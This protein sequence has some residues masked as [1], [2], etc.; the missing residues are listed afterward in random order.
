MSERASIDEVKQ[1]LSSPSAEARAAALAHATAHGL[2]AGS[3]AS[4]VAA[5][6]EDS[7]EAVRYAAMSAFR[8]VGRGASDAVPELLRM[9][10]RAD[11]DLHLRARAMHALGVVGPAAQ[12]AVSPLLVRSVGEDRRAALEALAQIVDERTPAAVDAVVG[13]LFDED[14]GVRT[15]VTRALSE[16]GDHLA[17]RALSRAEAELGGEV[18]GHAAVSVLEALRPRFGP[19]TRALAHRVLLERLTGVAGAALFVERDDAA[20]PPNV[21]LALFELGIEGEW[22]LFRCLAR[23]GSRLPRA[24]LADAPP[25]LAARITVEAELRPLSALAALLA[26][27]APRSG[28]GVEVL[29][30]RAERELRDKA[31]AF[32]PLGDVIVSI[33]RLATPL[34]RARATA[35][36]GSAI[37]RSKRLLRRAE[38]AALDLQRRAAEALALLAPG[39]Q[40]PEL[41]VT[42]IDEAHAERDAA[43]TRL[44]PIRA[45]LGGKEPR[46]QVRVAK[47]KELLEL[48]RA[49]AAGA[50]LLRSEKIRKGAKPEAVA[51]FV[52]EAV[53]ELRRQGPLD[54]AHVPALAALYGDA[55]VAE[56]GWEWRLVRQGTSRALG[57]VAPWNTHVVLPGRRIGRCFER[58]AEVTLLLSFNVLRTRGAP[59]ARR[60]AL[61][62]L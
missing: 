10:R 18:N 12:A 52:D 57:V 15:S 50:S 45:S 1:G 22:E 48:D 20:V 19:Q 27:L 30:S 31:P 35:L 39:E 28:F 38:S 61:V 55:L 6:L 44:P 56:L 40:L 25:R 47:A 9:M 43:A 16:A 8:S 58:G 62:H 37:T 41:E 33:A 59:P 29:L 2:D 42:P 46:P 5:R 49:R 54:A 32:Y 7:D 36:V 24:A 23:C 51:R 11:G 13:A 3:L 4:A 21:A 53:R 60:G 34:E 17:E 14:F 26:E